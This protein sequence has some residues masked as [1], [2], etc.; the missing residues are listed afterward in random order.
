[1]RNKTRFKS[2][3]YTFVFPS[4]RP[5]NDPQ[6]SLRR[7]PTAHIRVTCVRSEVTKR[8]GILTR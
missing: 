8:E 2:Y 6:E 1:M 5:T 4:L 3:S 7:R